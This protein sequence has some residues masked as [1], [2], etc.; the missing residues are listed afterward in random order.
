MKN[1]LKKIGSL[2]LIF[3]VMVLTAY[4]IKVEHAYADTYSAGTNIFADTFTRANS[5]T[6][7]NGWSELQVDASNPGIA[8]NQL[9]HNTSN[10]GVAYRNIGSYNN[11]I[12]TFKLTVPTSPNSDGV[13]FAIRHDG[14]NRNTD[15][16]TNFLSIGL[17]LAGGSFKVC[18]GTTVKGSTN[19]TFVTSTQYNFEWVVTSANYMEI[20]V[21]KTG[22]SRPLAPNLIIPAFT[23]GATG[24]NYA[25]GGREITGST[26]WDD[27]S[28][29]NLIT[30]ASHPSK[31][32]I[33]SR[34][35]IKSVFHNYLD[36]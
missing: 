4:N 34:V 33:K 14:S 13:G 28:M 22:T 32:N 26:L 9:S 20:R 19:F 25:F 8:S 5:N 18:D 23:V 6:V 1:F 7:G 10:V 3:S 29:D 36:Q 11:I 27:F 15:C 30:T 35:N 21:W 12:V 17:N 24:V 16:Q 2:F 31:I